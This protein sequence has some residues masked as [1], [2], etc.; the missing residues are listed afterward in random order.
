LVVFPLLLIAL[1]GTIG[2][3]LLPRKYESSTTILVRLDQTLA[4]RAGWEI[5]S[6]LESQL[7]NFNEIIKS[8]TVIAA[9]AESLGMNP[10]TL[11]EGDRASL[12][13]GVGENIVA[14]RRSPDSFTITFVDSDPRRAQQGARVLGDLFIQTKLGFEVQSSKAT[15]EYLERKVDEYRLGL[16][17]NART[18]V[19]ALRQGSDEGS[20][21]VRS[22]YLQAD[23]M[24]RTISVTRERMREA[25]EAMGS[26]RSLP[27]LFRGNRSALQTEAGKQPLLELSR[28]RIPFASDLQVLFAEYESASRRY[29]SNYPAVQKLEEQIISLLDRMSKSLDSEYY[30]LE[31]QVTALEKKRFALIG[32]IQRSSESQR[33]NVGKESN[34]ETMRRLYDDAMMRL[35]QA[36]VT[37]E[38]TSRGANQF[39]ILDPANLPFAP[40]KPNR[41]R[42]VLGSVLA[43]LLVSLL[44]VVLAELLDT[45]LRAPRD[46]EVYQKPIIALLPAA[47]G[48]RG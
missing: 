6:A 14:E 22:F 34:Y 29:T 31:A 17:N 38:I 37:Q 19:S 27:Q 1:L 44:G 4:P 40:S 21:A 25:E 42:I 30:R 41:P 45:T 28:M 2:A 18:L 16:E 10:S 15:V 3:Y 43:G 8:R 48:K 26:L 20:P 39:I 24:E 12:L 35:E 32:E 5:N 47:R 33:M 13:A 36:R 9:L 46:L 11:S 23:E 7:R